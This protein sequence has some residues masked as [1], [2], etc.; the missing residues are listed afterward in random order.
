MTGKADNKKSA[1]REMPLKERIR[2]LPESP[3]VYVF[4]NRQEKVIY[5]GKAVNLRSR[6]RSYFAK[7]SDGRAFFELLRRDIADVSHVVTDTEKEALILECNLIKQFKPRYN[8]LLTDDASYICL[9]IDLNEEYPRVQLPSGRERALV[10]KAQRDGGSER[11][12]LWFGPYASAGKARSTLRELNRIFPLRKCSNTQFGRR[13]RPCIQHQMGRCLGPCSG[14]V[15]QAEYNDVLEE[16]I[17]VLNGRYEKVKLLLTERMERESKLMHFERAAEMRD[18]LRAIEAT[19]EK[20][21]M[22]VVGGVD[23]DIFGVY[24]DAK[25]IAIGVLFVRDGKLGEL[26]SYHFDQ[27]HFTPAEVFESFVEQ[28]YIRQ[29]RFIPQEVLVPFDIGSADALAEML[30]E[31]RGRVARSSEAWTWAQHGQRKTVDRGTRAGG[32]EGLRKVRVIHPR[33]GEKLRLVE[34]AARNAEAAFKS[35]VSDA[36]LVEDLLQSL[37]EKLGLRRP[38]KCIEC[39]DISNFQGH[40][41]VG[42][43][44]SFRDGKP[45]KSHYRKFKI[46]TITQ[47]DDFAMMREVIRRRYDP[48]KDESRPDLTIV[49][50]GKGQ[51]SAA[52]TVFAELGIDDV[53]LVGLAKS[54]RKPARRG[55]GA[56]GETPE[57]VF[58]PGRSDPVVL[59]QDSQEMYYLV[60]IRDEAHRFA[61]SY[62]RLLRKKRQ[63]YHPLD[64]I[65]GVGDVKKK[66]LLEEFG[67]Y[68]NIRDASVEELQR[69]KGI[70]AK[71]ARAIHRHLSD[72]NHR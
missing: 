1:E 26:N 23:R 72:L 68:G 66:R 29:Q 65:P 69:V 31:K 2:T 6:V 55:R 5:V 64:G 39:F 60:R 70:T 24:R 63:G 57:R 41:A 19:F 9:R 15:E 27:Q 48:A 8:V 56:A 58:L 4:R 43:M 67:D 7:T 46:R 51:L 22:N 49:D 25:S 13:R 40:L 35:R 45:D 71:D 20:Q 54:K 38:P 42:S 21:R 50:G 10:S 62:H 34:L 12:V 30:T 3:G 32:R 14:H 11:N 59:P 17:M 37:K 33:R 61:I 44:V 36:A 28:F 47:S 18:R 16:A 53:D 52:A